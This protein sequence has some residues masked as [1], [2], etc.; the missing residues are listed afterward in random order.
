MFHGASQT[1]F[2]LISLTKSSKLVLSKVA[3]L[4]FFP[5]MFHEKQD[6]RIDLQASG[7]HA[8]G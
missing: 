7:D 3:Y 5:S 2:K 6:D 1:W 4:I 8:K